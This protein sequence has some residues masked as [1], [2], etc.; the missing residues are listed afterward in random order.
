MG[1]APPGLDQPVVLRPTRLAGGDQGTAHPGAGIVDELGIGRRR[2]PAQFDHD[3]PLRPE[4]D[5]ERGLNLP[6]ASSDQPAPPGPTC[7]GQLGAQLAADLT[8]AV[9]QLAQ[10]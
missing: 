3:G 6:V 10:G 5:C 8:L 7:L 1:G 4:P 2:L 9:D